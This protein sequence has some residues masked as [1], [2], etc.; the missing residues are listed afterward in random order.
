MIRVRPLPKGF[1]S[2]LP[3]ESKA[4]TEKPEHPIY[5]IPSLCNLFGSISQK[6]FINDNIG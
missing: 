3:N 1:K 2:K 6:G 5:L 4:Y